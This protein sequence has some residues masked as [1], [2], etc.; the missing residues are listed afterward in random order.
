MML[1]GPHEALAEQSNFVHALVGL[2]GLARVVHA[3]A[4]GERRRVGTAAEPD[5]FVHLLLAVASLGEAIGNLA[6]PADEKPPAPAAGAG[7][8]WL[9]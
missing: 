1:I 8:R 3:L 9:R 7:G 2:A 4:S 6:P 5:D